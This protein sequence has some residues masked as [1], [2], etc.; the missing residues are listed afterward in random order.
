MVVRTGRLRLKQ[1]T[2]VLAAWRAAAT[3]TA[4]ASVGAEPSSDTQLP[5]DPMP[6]MPESSDTESLSAGSAGSDGESTEDEDAPTA[7]EIRRNFP[8]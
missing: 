2:R 6:A 5:D 8:A 4:A 3:T 1:L 7:E